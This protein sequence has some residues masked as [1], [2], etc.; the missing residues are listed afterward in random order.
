MIV[1][2][3]FL[4]E[5][6]FSK[7]FS[8]KTEDSKFLY[9]L[10]YYHSCF[11]SIYNCCRKITPSAPSV[12][13]SQPQCSPRPG[14]DTRA[15]PIGPRQLALL[16]SLSDEAGLC[17]APP[18]PIATAASGHATR[19]HSLCIA[20]SMFSSALRCHSRSAASSLILVSGGV[21]CQGFMSLP[22]PIDLA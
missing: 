13:G 7:R 17:P 21:R 16:L 14:G 11:D 3:F 22:P 4:F 8:P 9:R 10:T 15:R 12:S 5:F 2:C 6:L 20:A 1:L 18:E 19:S